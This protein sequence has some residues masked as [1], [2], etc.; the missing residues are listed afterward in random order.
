[1]R[2]L[3]THSLH[4]EAVEAGACPGSP[5]PQRRADGVVF[6]LDTRDKFEASLLREWI[7]QTRSTP[8]SVTAGVVTLPRDRVDE[9]FAAL[10]ELDRDTWMQP[11][12]IVWLPR[13]HGENSGLLRDVFFARSENPGMIRRRYIA[14]R[15][16]ERMRYVAGQGATL[17]EL[18]TRYREIH[19]DRRATL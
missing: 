13:E 6:L 2:S 15:K 16:P 11:L 14:W 12:R 19:G 4:E 9:E 8:D 10:G 3:D 5:W 1:M 18:E 7:K 17:A